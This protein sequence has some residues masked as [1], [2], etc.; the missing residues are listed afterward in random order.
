MSIELVPPDSSLV[1]LAIPVIGGLGSV[2]GAVAGSALV[3]LPTF[4][5][6]PLLDSVFGD[7]GKQIG[8]QLALALR[9][10]VGRGQQIGTSVPV[11]IAR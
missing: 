11:H 1:L 5:I 4:F 10:G 8:F 9:M 2:V 6:S 3:Y 7:F